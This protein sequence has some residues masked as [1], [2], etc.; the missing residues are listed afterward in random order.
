MVQSSN[1]GE[2][3]FQNVQLSEF[4]NGQKHLQ[5]MQEVIDE[6][7]KNIPRK[8]PRSSEEGDDQDVTQVDPEG[9]EQQEME[10]N[11]EDGSNSLSDINNNYIL[12]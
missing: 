10:D 11:F 8:R 1:T 4:F 12:C 7:K 9:D 6:S 5:Y 2:V 3:Y